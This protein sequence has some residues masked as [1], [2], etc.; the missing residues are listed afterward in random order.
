MSSTFYGLN[1]AKTGLYASQKAM[2]LTG[3]NIA[4]A[5]TEGYTRQVLHQ[6]SIE[7]KVT[8]EIITSGEIVHIGGG[9]KVDY[10]D[11]VRNEF[12]DIQYR[13][14]NSEL[15]DWNVKSEAMYY[16]ENVFNEPS[17]TGISSVLNEFYSS[18]S[19]L[20]ND[21]SAEEVRSLVRQNA[22]TLCETMNYYAKQLSNLQNEQDDAISSTVFELNTMVDQI[23]DYNEQI[24][25][26][27]RTGE[28]ANDLNDKRNLLL[29]QLSQ[30]VDISYEYNDRNEV[31][32]YFG[33]L[34][35]IEGDR[36]DYCLID[37]ND[38]NA[39]YHMEVTEDI[40]GHYG[41]ENQLCT[42]TFNGIDIDGSSLKGGKV[43]GYFDMRDGD[44]TDNIGI[45]Y[46]M[47]QLDDFARGIVDAYNN[48]HKQGYTIPD[49][50]NGGVS[51]ADVIFFDD[52][53]GD[54]DAVNAKN[55]NISADIIESVWNIAASDKQVDLDAPNTQEGNN[56][57]ALK[58][59]AVSSST[60]LDKIGN[61]DNFVAG[62][63]SELGVRAR[64]CNEMYESQDIVVENVDNLRS[65]I[66]GVSIDEEVTMLLTFQRAYQASSRVLT[67]IDQMLD[68]LINGTGVV[69][70]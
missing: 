12:L 43:K 33:K 28:Q 35:N 8:Q 41:E 36:D 23:A 10:V 37:A 62:I 2:E 52:Q 32:V 30:L 65:S 45:K 16:L 29:D 13:T 17:D 47:N 34:S 3:H 50:E 44:S 31:S 7:G 64:Q 40:T 18:I 59:E 51:R 38:G 26:F 70:L 42:V 4:N 69:G 53:G 5:N 19:T 54:L 61:I 21:A 1:I 39:V 14:Q 22:I 27:E 60:T 11:Q 67:T 20:S 46:F 55:M 6:S 24:V 56:K 63:V 9:V 49:A 66:S 48:V 25:K 57:N 68:K 58:L 15:Y